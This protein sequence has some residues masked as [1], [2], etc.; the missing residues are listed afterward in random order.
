M[1]STKACP[2]HPG[3]PAERCPRCEV[4]IARAEDARSGLWDP[5]DD[6][7][8]GEREYERFLERQGEG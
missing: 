7:G 6:V 4:A 8:R 1:A 2:S 5:P 3:H